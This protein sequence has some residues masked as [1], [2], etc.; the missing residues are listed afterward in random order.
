MMAKKMIELENENSLLRA[1]LL[2]YQLRDG[3]KERLKLL[4]QKRNEALEAA[5]EKYR[6]EKTA[7][8]NDVTCDCGQCADEGYDEVDS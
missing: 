4:L 2:E 6:R 3:S 8:S 1:K 7:R 5:K